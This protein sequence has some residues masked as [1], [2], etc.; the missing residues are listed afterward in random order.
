[1]AKKKTELKPRPFCGYMIT[2]ATIKEIG[3]WGIR[4]PY[5]LNKLPDNFKNGRAK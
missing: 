2:I 1:M 3:G 5:C 4:C